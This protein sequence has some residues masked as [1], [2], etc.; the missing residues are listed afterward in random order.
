MAKDESKPS[1]PSEEEVDRDFL[2]WAKEHAGR[3]DETMAR[4]LDDTAHLIRR[5]RKLQTEYSRAW[6]RSLTK[7][8]PEP[9]GESLE[10]EGEIKKQALVAAATEMFGVKERTVWNAIAPESATAAPE[11]TKERFIAIV[12]DNLALAERT[13]NWAAAKLL[14]RIL[15]DPLPF[16]EHISLQSS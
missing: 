7:E 14:R 5:P 1:T 2:A 16:F 3:D 8:P 6:V 10:V 9:V 15:R 12:A 11:L 13:N 4:A